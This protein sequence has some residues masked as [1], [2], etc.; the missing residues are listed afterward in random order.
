[1][2]TVTDVCG[3][4]PLSVDEHH[5]KLQTLP[6]IPDQRIDHDGRP[7]LDD[8]VWRY[9]VR[10]P[11]HKPTK[12]LATVRL[13]ADVMAWLKSQGKG[14]QTRLNAILREAMLQALRHETSV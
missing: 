13:D 14:Y 5:M 2:K 11:L 9:A 4:L 7:S 6:A 12:I 8:A 1:M 3:A 10:S